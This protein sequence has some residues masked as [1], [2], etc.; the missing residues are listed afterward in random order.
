MEQHLIMNLVDRVL[1]VTLEPLKENKKFQ[2]NLIMHTATLSD[3]FYQ[4]IFSEVY[5]SICHAMFYT[6]S[7]SLKQGWI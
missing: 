6:W 7:F 5:K 1:L 2:T 4:D 3:E